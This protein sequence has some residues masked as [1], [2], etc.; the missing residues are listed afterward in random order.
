[1]SCLVE[2]NP[3][4]KST[5][6]FNSW[7]INLLKRKNNLRNCFFF[8]ISH[9]YCMLWRKKTC[10]NKSKMWNKSDGIWSALILK[11]LDRSKTQEST[12]RVRIHPDRTETF[13]AYFQK[14]N[15]GRG[16]ISGKY[17]RKF[18]SLGTKFFHVEIMDLSESKN[19]K[20]C[21]DRRKNLQWPWT[22]SLGR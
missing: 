3:D 9:E 15:S 16:K 4:F 20:S 11:R 7:K 22:L 12:T 18:S 5:L 10:R 8:A 1:M 21:C 13:L 6:Q 14:I 2:T 17:F 19:Q